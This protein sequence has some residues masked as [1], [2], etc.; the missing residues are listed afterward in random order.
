MRAVIYARFSSLNQRDASIEDQVRL[1]REWL[2]RN[3]FRGQQTY[4][5]RAMSGSD[6]LRPGIQALIED[7]RSGKVD[8]VI[9]EALDRTAEIKPTLPLSSSTLPSPT[10]S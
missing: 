1:C 6:M 7:C 9:A 8:L 5:D 2:E 3:D 4:A 10:S